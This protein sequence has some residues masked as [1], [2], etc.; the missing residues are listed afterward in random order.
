M[1]KGDRSKGVRRKRDRSKYLSRNK[2]TVYLSLKVWLWLQPTRK[3]SQL[4][5]RKT[6]KGK[7]R[8][9]TVGRRKCKE[10]KGRKA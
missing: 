4:G 8:R 9:R 1:K 3:K 6:W 2:K 10:E 5:Q 7:E